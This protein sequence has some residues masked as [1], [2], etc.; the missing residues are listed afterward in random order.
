MGG[1][2]TVPRAMW[3]DVDLVVFC[4]GVIGLIGEVGGWDEAE[5]S[6]GAHQYVQL[7]Y[8]GD[9]DRV[10]EGVSAQAVAW[11]TGG[12]ALN[13]AIG[14]AAYKAAE[15]TGAL[16]AANRVT[17]NFDCR[18]A[19]APPFLEDATKIAH[20]MYDWKIHPSSPPLNNNI[21]KRG[22]KLYLYLDAAAASG[23]ANM[24]LT[25]RFSSR[26]K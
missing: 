16:S 18:A 3:P 19:V 11:G 1:Q 4:P 2:L 13:F 25:L 12:T 21:I 20:G 5:L 17:E 23:L 22:E 7:P 10:L 24:T 26:I 15:P 6:V 14:K 8:V 9:Q